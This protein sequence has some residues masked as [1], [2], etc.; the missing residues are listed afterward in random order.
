MNVINRWFQP[1]SLHSPAHG[2]EKKASW[3][4]LFYDLIYVAAFIQLGN[5]LSGDMSAAGVLGFAGLFLP[6]WLTWTAFTFYANRFD[7]DDAVHR[8]LVFLQ[9]FGLGAMAVC[10]EEVFVGETTRFTAA[11]LLVRVLLVA[12]YGRVWRHDKAAGEMARRYTLGFGLGACIWAAALVTSV[13]SDSVWVFGLWALGMLVDFVVP[14]TPRARELALR[15]PPDILHMSERYGILTIIVL[16]ESFV[17]MLGEIAGR[18]AQEREAIVMMGG[19]ALPAWAAVSNSHLILMAGL[20]LVLTCSLWWLYFDDVAGSRITAKPLAPF[21]WVYTH[22]PFHMAV[23]AAGVA[24]KKAVFFPVDEPAKV[25]YAALLCGSLALAFFMVALIDLVT[26]RRVTEVK[27]QVRVVFRVTS[28]TVLLLLIPVAGFMPGSVFLALLAGLCVVQVLADLSMAP[29]AAHPM[30]HDHEAQHVF[31]QLMPADPELAGDDEDDDSQQHPPR[32][33][34]VGDAVRK[35]TPNELRRDVY[36]HLMEASWTQIFI[37]VGVLYIG[38]NVVFAALYMLD[39]S[40]VAALDPRSFFDAFSFS[41]Q[42]MASIGYGVMNPV[43][44]WANAL[45]AVEAG[46][47]IIGIALITGIMFAKASRPRSSV[48]FSDKVVISTRHGVPTLM[49]RVGNARGN[50]VVEANITVTALIEEVSPEGHKLR[51]LWDLE[52]QRSRTP[53]FAL[54]WTVFHALDEASPLHGLSADNAH[55]RLFNLVVSLTGHDSTY[56]QTTHARKLYYP[57]DFRFDS[58]FVDV[59]STL[60]DGR[61]LVDYDHFH[62]IERDAGDDT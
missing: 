31:D 28:G 57:E 34:D 47:S 18:F 24:I 20:G 9:M 61:L 54:T 30:G 3:L 37:G 49:F 32:R 46:L 27:E 6:L 2:V 39:P 51:R 21:I 59:I 55:E 13:L 16:G 19:E 5:Q 15:H 40:G 52:L 1:P 14:L 45:V 35:G 4:E 10:I 12:M 23:V 44:D 11:Y 42:T 8:G 60:P 25:K 33:R 7:T 41:V 43:S 26:H 56:A 22:L 17:K 48:L 38:T 36:F 62:D 53:I 50:D 58:R 29:Q